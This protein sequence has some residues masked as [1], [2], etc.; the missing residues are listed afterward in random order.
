[1]DGINKNGIMA[2]NAVDDHFR[3]SNLFLHPYT[4]YG[5][6]LLTW[7]NLFIC[8]FIIFIH[9]F[10]YICACLHASLF[11]YLFIYVFTQ[12]INILMTKTM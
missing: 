12:Y 4:F 10:A 2:S 11:T 9:L 8:S 3:K 5:P 1:M 6:K 7:K